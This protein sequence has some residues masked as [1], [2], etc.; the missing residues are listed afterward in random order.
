MALIVLLHKQTAHQP[1]RDKAGRWAT[2]LEEQPVQNVMRIFCQEIPVCVRTSWG[3]REDALIAAINWMI[4]GLRRVKISDPIILFLLYGI[5]FINI[6][7]LN[8][9]TIQA[10]AGRIFVIH[11]PIITDQQQVLHVPDDAAGDATE[12][13]ED[14]VHHQ[15]VQP[16][17]TELVLREGPG[18]DPGR[19][20][21]H[22]LP[23]AIVSVERQGWLRK[24]RRGGGCW[25]DMRSEGEISGN[26]NT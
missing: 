14:H 13:V 11:A 3:V 22:H 7:S 1:C 23:R 5:I 20:G 2:L 19:R 4:R 9:S 6:S 15:S 24:G 17:H 21:T 26:R 12:A 8:A 10:V 16:R 18:A 25:V